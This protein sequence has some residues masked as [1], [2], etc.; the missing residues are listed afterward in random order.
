M[1]GGGETFTEDLYYHIAPAAIRRGYNFMTVD[2]PGQGDLPFQGV[3]FRPDFETPMK[4]V[5]D[6]ALSRPDVDPARL[7][8][9]GIS[10]GGYIVP[11]AE[12]MRIFELQHTVDQYE[13]LFGE[14]SSRPA[15]ASLPGPG[16]R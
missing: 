14:R 1:I 10:A 13:A 11:R 7:A 8:A 9:Y 2:M 3:Y 15:P 12:I 5:V 16:G 4:A 6:Y